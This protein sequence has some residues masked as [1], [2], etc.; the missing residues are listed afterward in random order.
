MLNAALLRGQAEP[1]ISQG[2]VQ[3][4]PQRLEWMGT[5]PKIT[6]S[7]RNL[8]SIHVMRDELHKMLVFCYLSH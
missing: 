2:Q 1:W 6:R 8:F 5:K 3:V 4:R 7:L